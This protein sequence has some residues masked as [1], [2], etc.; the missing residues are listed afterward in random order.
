MTQPPT[1]R[2]FLKS[3][4]LLG[5]GAS[6]FGTYA[7]LPSS[8]FFRVDKLTGPGGLAPFIAGDDLLRLV[9]LS[10][11][12]KSV[13]QALTVNREVFHLGRAWM[14]DPAGLQ[15]VLDESGQLWRAEQGQDRGFTQFALVAGHLA[16]R[17][18]DE[19][20]GTEEDDAEA[21]RYRDTYLFKQLQNARPHARR[22][23]VDG[24]VP[25]V[26][27]AEVAELLHL[28][29]QRNLIRMHTL[30]PEFSDIETWL[31]EFLGYYAELKAENLRYGEV[32]CNPGAE[33]LRRYVLEPEFYDP[34]DAPILAARQLANGEVVGRVMPD[35]TTASSQ[36]GRAL[37]R[38]M[39]VL[40]MV[41]SQVMGA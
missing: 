39:D 25:E 6:S 10:D 18:M 19:A 13:R 32:F 23:A 31:T 40:G 37:L 34:E 28:M 7:G 26:T 12:P 21:S 36:Y 1:R 29:Q 38:G 9:A 11:L 22:V 33:K 4:L 30:R 27:P 35:L 20:L 17:A 41:S 15:T 14:V 8:S 5:L 16:A 24:P 2:D 3:S